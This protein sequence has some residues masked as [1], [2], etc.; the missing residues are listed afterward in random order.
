MFLCFDS[1]VFVLCQEDSED[2]DDLDDD[3]LSDWNLSKSVKYLNLPMFCISRM[4]V[5]FNVHFICVR[6]VVLQ[7]C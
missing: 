2:E 5:S 7:Q 4:S 3:T 1:F 6:R